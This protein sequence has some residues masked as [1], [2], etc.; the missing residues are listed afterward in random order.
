MVPYLGVAVRAHTLALAGS[1]RLAGGVGPAGPVLA[2]C[3]EENTVKKQVDAQTTPSH[4]LCEMMG[5]S[6]G[7]TSPKRGASRFFKIGVVVIPVKCEKIL[8][9]RVFYPKRNLNAAPEDEREN[10]YTS[11]F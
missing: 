10:F 8:L 5:K 7:K 3:D 11:H 6:L 4:R 1:V 2:T 9:P